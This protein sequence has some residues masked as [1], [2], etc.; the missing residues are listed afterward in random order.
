M[1]RNVT[2]QAMRADADLTGPLHFDAPILPRKIAV[3]ASYTPSL[4]NFRLEL[5]KRMV[6]AGH[7]VT[8]FA[9]EDDPVVK[10][11]LTSIGVDFVLMPMARTGLNPVE[12]FATLSFL[13]R[14]FRRLQP[15]MVLPYTMKPIIYAGIAARI[16]G[17][18]H[19]CFLV[20]GLG[21]VFSD[22]GAASFKGRLV[23]M[24]SVLLYKLAFSGAHV[25]FAYNNADDEDLRR[26]NMLKD[27]SLIELVPGSGVDLQHYHFSEAS[28]G[29]PKF[30]LVARLLKDKGILEYVEA[31]RIVKRS[32][33]DAEFRLLGHFDPNPTAISREDITSWVEEGVIDYLGETRDVRP[34][35]ADCNVFVLPSYYREGIPRSILEALSSGRAVIT[36]DLP[37]CSDTVEHGVNG[38]L[39]PPRNAQRLANAMLEFVRDPKRART[40]GRSSREL[41]ERKF[42]VHQVNHQLMRR[43]GLL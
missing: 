34:F 41:A 7:S 12:D 10:A 9:P 15:D 1:K 27:K 23:R 11:D 29:R 22:A 16:A 25:V 17:V 28:E 21:H 42:D 8:A 43:M 5:L 38:Y 35:L 40:M 14:Q 36:S 39:V 37:G 18:G 24:F 33:P 26:H 19:R 32:F 6:E 30:L 20:T 31:A 13:I 4:T 2:S 3:V